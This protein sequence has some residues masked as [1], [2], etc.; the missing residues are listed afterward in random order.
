[1]SEGRIM[2]A[3]QRADQGEARFLRDIFGR[4]G[5]ASETC[6]VPSH[7]RQPTPQ[8]RLEGGR[9]PGLG[10]ED[11]DFLLDCL[12]RARHRCITVAPE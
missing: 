11:E 5:I 8:N 10:R 4:C 1:M 7:G 3:C 2:E 6:G 9:V 12:E